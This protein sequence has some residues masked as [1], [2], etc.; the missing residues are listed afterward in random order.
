MNVEVWP[1]SDISD[2]QHSGLSV[3]TCCG[4]GESKGAV[5]FG[6]QSPS[7]A[8][9]FRCDKKVCSHFTESANT[10]K[11]AKNRQEQQQILVWTI[12]TNNV[13]SHMQQATKLVR[14]QFNL[15]QTLKQ[16]I[17]GNILEKVSMDYSLLLVKCLSNGFHNF[18]SA[19]LYH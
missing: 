7:S 4:T 13:K 11:W 12:N 17:K 8:A 16:H 6:S 2:I 15:M 14:T 19:L 18:S 3:T 10:E 5:K 1:S 9:N